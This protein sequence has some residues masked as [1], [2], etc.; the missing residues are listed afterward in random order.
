MKVR[1]LLS[2]LL[3]FAFFESSLYAQHKVSLCTD[4]KVV[5]ECAK[6]AGLTRRISNRTTLDSR[7][8]KFTTLCRGK[9]FLTFSV[10]SVRSDSTSY[11]I[12]CFEGEQYGESFITVE[13]E[14]LEA[15]ETAG[16]RRYLNDGRLPFAE[17]DEL[18]TKIIA[19]YENHGFPFTEVSLNNIQTEGGKITAELSV[20]RGNFIIVDTIIVKGDAKLRAA[21]LYPYLG[22]RKRKAYSEN[23][24]RRVPEKVTAMP[25]ATETRP[26][27]VEFNTDK[28]SLYLFLDKKRTNRF[29][30]FMA[31]VPV[32]ERTG[33]VGIA[34]EV[35]LALK[36][37]FG[38]G[39]S[40]DAEW[41]APGQK[42]QNLR[43]AAEFPYLFRTPIG[44]D[45]QFALN[46]TDTSYLNMNYR[47]GIRYSFLTNGFLKAYFNYL[48]SDVLDANL[49][50][51]SDNNLNYIDYRKRMYGLEFSFSRLDYIYNPRKGVELSVDVS[52]GRRKIIRN[53][54]ADSAIY[55]G[56][57][58]ESANYSVT[59]R[60]NGYIPLHKRWVLKLGMAG[61]GIFG[62]ENLAND[63]FKIGGMK[64]LRGFAEDEIIATAYG[65]ITTELRFLFAR[66][67]YF[68]IFFDAAWYERNLQG[69]YVSDF[70]FGFGAGLAFDTKAGIFFLNYALGRQFGNPISFKNGKIHFGIKV[71]F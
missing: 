16:L 21:Y 66:I 39:E 19:Y 64:S 10:D 59:T 1:Y 7:L 35:N 32:D 12:Y 5:K 29:D 9:G 31:I 14:A 65:T 67:A 36:N 54:K 62:A 42:S 49:L 45:L 61:G 71:T 20:D 50:Q 25:F 8:T 68:N 15:V 52:A 24:M 30:G 53:A 11:Y 40:F 6:K 17:Y 41:R 58:M 3:F 37:L 63:L 28:A 43:L 70:P 18:S 38:I 2:V 23:T 22:I 33:R 51:I 4:N 69:S 47:I 44:A 13:G 46:K 48:T 34:G 60:V 56:I 57:V 55:S 27:G 26:S